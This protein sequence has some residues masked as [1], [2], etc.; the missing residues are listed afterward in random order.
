MQFIVVW[1]IVNG[2]YEIIVGEWCWWV[3]QQVGLEKILV[4]VC[5][6]LDEVVIVMVLIENIQ[7]EDFNLIEEVVVL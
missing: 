6:V 2:C 1:L 4:L 7:C 5:D 3:S